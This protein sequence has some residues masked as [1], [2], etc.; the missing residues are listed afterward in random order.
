MTV[1][2]GALQLNQSLFSDEITRT[3]VQFALLIGRW[4]SFS[5]MIAP[6]TS[7]RRYKVQRFKRQ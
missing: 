6:Q 3:L 2:R 5:L 4:A 7:P 1:K